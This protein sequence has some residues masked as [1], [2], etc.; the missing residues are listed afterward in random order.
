VAEGVE[1]AVQAG[2]LRRS[3]CDSGQGYLFGRP[4][5][6]A[7]VEKVMYTHLTSVDQPVFASRLQPAGPLRR[8]TRTPL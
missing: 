1:T 3:G 7:E 2:H 6:A 4:A 8:R 5:C